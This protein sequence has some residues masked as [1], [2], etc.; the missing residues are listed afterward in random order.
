[1]RHFRDQSAPIR[2]FVPEVRTDTRGRSP[3]DRRETEPKDEGIG[4]P[5]SEKTMHS[6]A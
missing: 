4:V 5:E 6:P 3:A 1:M 2:R